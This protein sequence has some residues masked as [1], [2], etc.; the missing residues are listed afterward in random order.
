MIQTQAQEIIEQLQGMDMQKALSREIPV[1][2]FLEILN[3][4]ASTISGHRPEFKHCLDAFSTSL[5][6]SIL[7]LL[8]DNKETDKDLN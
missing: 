6:V 3:K 7:M 2:V 1:A 5:H 8:D 4:C